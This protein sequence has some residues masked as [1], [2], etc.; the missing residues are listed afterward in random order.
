[1]PSPLN[2]R[3]RFRRQHPNTT[4]TGPIAST[5]GASASLSRAPQSRNGSQTH[6]A[7]PSSRPTSAGGASA[8]TVAPS[9]GPRGSLDSNRTASLVH[10]MEHATAMSNAY[11]Q[12]EQLGFTAL[13]GTAWTAP[14]IPRNI[15]PC[16]VAA[17]LQNHQNGYNNGQVGRDVP[18]VTGTQ[19]QAILVSEPNRPPSRP[20]RRSTSQNRAGAPLPNHKLRDLGRLRLP[21]EALDF[22]TTC[23]A[24]HT[25]LVRFILL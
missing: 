2:L 15:H 12:G 11:E 1:M 14:A 6:L 19:Q 25:E 4:G 20:G 13:S 8:L 10:Y 3:Q 9:M 16:H 22:L 18:E 5:A 24:T 23:Q 17:Y 21:D 7:P